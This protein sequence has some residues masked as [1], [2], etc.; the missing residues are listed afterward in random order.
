VLIESLKDGLIFGH[1][2]NYIKV[3]VT[4][5]QKMINTMIGIHLHENLGSYMKGKCP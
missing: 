3:E 4:G 1:T 5:D 2:D